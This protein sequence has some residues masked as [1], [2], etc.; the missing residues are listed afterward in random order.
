MTMPAH[1]IFPPSKLFDARMFRRA[2]TPRTIP[3]G[4]STRAEQISDQIASSAWLL[5]DDPPD[6][7]SG[8][9]GTTVVI[10][11]SVRVRTRHVSRAAAAALRS[12]V[13]GFQSGVRQSVGRRRAIE[14]FVTAITL[15]Q[16][17]AHDQ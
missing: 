2:I 15:P 9:A 4:G 5:T 17:H 12:L 11:R 14:Y 1:A 6:T 16:I 3:T 7:G 13:A 10:V 8:F